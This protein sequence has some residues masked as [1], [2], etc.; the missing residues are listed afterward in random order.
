MFPNPHD[1]LQL[2]KHNSKK[3]CR[4]EGPFP[5]ALTTPFKIPRIDLKRQS[6]SA[7]KCVHDNHG[8]KT[9]A[10]QYLL[11]YVTNLVAPGLARL[12]GIRPASSSSSDM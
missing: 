2:R 3:L 5:P 7:S 11:P 6:T 4:V 10:H 12:T 8:S 1:I 9:V